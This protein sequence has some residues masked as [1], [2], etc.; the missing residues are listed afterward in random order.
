MERD[1]Q[2]ETAASAKESEA[3]MEFYG[4]TL[5]EFKKQCKYHIK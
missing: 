1:L 3:E 2:T 4:F 5:D